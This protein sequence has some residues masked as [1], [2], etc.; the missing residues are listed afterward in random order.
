MLEIFRNRFF[1]ALCNFA[2]SL[3][4][5][6]PKPCPFGQVSITQKAMKKIFM[7]RGNE[8]SKL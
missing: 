8:L 5:F 6:V 2:P 7:M 1:Y 4:S 3:R